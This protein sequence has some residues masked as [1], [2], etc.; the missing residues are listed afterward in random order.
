MITEKG[1]QV[2]KVISQLGG[3][4]EDAPEPEALES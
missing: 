1:Y 4:L 2:L 3:V